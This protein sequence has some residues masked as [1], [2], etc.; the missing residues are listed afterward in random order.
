[1]KIKFQ[2]ETDNV[3]GLKVLDLDSPEWASKPVRDEDWMGGK[4]DVIKADDEYFKIPEG[5]DSF[6]AIFEAD[7]KITEFDALGLERIIKQ[8]IAPYVK[9]GVI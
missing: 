4:V 3:S 7:N 1:M 9:I 2:V 8:Y 5:E 6:V